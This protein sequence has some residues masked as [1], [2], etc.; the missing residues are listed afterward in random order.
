MQFIYSFLWLISQGCCIVLV[1]VENRRNLLI[2][3][4]SPSLNFN[5]TRDPTEGGKINGQERFYSFSRP[6]EVQVIENT[7]CYRAGFN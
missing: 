2:A 5:L 3:V 1:E 7:A 6:V 4:S